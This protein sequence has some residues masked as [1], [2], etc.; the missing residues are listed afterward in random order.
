MNKF[1]KENSQRWMRWFRWSLFHF[2][3]LIHTELFKKHLSNTRWHVS[4]PIWTHKT[5]YQIIP[6]HFKELSQI[7]QHFLSVL[8]LLFLRILS[9]NIAIINPVA[10]CYTQGQVFYYTGKYIWIINSWSLVW[11]LY[12]ASSFWALMNPE[13]PKTIVLIF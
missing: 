1:N 5:A 11:C 13:S 2:P 6:D 4:L 12:T 10:L 8:S 9:K 3:S 7:Q